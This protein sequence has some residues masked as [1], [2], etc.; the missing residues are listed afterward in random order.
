MHKLTLS[1]P[2]ERLEEFEAWFAQTFKKGTATCRVDSFAP[3]PGSYSFTYK[4]LLTF[5]S[6]KGLLLT[7]T[8][9]GAA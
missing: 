3:V 2:E 8:T 1:V 6:E 4:I 9:W 7:K 5:R